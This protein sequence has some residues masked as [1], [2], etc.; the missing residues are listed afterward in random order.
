MIGLQL[1]PLLKDYHEKSFLHQNICPDTIS[2]GKGYNNHTL[3]FSDLYQTKKY[4]N[5]KI[6]H[7]EMKTTVKITTDL[8]PFMT[9]NQLHYQQMS[10]RDDVEIIVLMLIYFLRGSLP[11]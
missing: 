5:H 9:I 10:R 2:I 4:R 8:S 7:I 11:W 3:Y 1:F 6:K